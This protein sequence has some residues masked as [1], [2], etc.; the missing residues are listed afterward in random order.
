MHKLASKTMIEILPEKLLKH[1]EAKCGNLATT[2]DFF[3]VIGQVSWFVEGGE[4]G[5]LQPPPPAPPTP[6][7]VPEPEPEAEPEA[8]ADPEAAPEAPAEE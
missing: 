4:P 2:P 3:D 1:I 8:E 7:P 5:Q 6:E